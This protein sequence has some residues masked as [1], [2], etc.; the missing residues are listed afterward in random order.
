MGH[1]V[2]CRGGGAAYMSW[3]SFDGFWA[4][5]PGSVFARCMGSELN[6]PGHVDAALCRPKS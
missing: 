1:A 3:T 6:L 2:Q 5:F 4:L